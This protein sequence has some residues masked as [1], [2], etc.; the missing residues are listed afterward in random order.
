MDSSTY[1]Q[2]SLFAMNVNT[3]LFLVD[4]M[5]TDFSYNDVSDEFKEWLK[6]NQMAQE[7]SE[8]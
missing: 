3:I 4:P 5:T 1:T 8:A 6:K 2:I 7:E